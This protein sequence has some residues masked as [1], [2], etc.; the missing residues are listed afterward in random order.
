MGDDEEEDE[1]EKKKKERAR[2]SVNRRERSAVNVHQENSGPLLLAGLDLRQN[3][4]IVDDQAYR[5][6]Q[7]E[8]VSY[9]ND[10]AG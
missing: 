8:P 1:E 9:R 3:S 4:N 2:D 5:T 10:R 7:I 6:Q